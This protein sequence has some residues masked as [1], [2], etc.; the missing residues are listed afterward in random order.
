MAPKSISCQ[1][2]AN[3]EDNEPN[4]R[5]CENGHS[6]GHLDYESPMVR[7]SQNPS[8]SIP[9]KGQGKGV[10]ATPRTPGTDDPKCRRDVQQPTRQPLQQQSI[11]RYGHAAVY[12]EAQEAGALCGVHA[13]NCMLQRRAVDEHKM[14][15]IA[16]TL[17]QREYELLGDDARIRGDGNAGPDGNFTVQVLQEAMR[18]QTGGWSFTDTRNPTIRVRVRIKSHLEKGYFV[19]P[20]GHWYVLRRVTQGAAL[21]WYNLDS[22]SGEGPRRITDAEVLRIILDTETSGG[23]V[24]LAQTD[25]G[26]PPK[27]TMSSPMAAGVDAPAVTRAH[28]GRAPA[29]NGTTL[30]VA[31]DFSGMDMAGYMLR[32]AAVPF[33]H[34]FASDSS[35]AAREHL[36]RNHCVEAIYECVTQRPLGPYSGGRNGTADGEEIDLFIAGPPCQSWSLNRVGAKGEDD[37]RGRLFSESTTF[38]TEAKP[39]AF[40]LE[41]VCGLISR[42]GGRYLSRTLE[43]LR[44][45]GYR[46]RWARINPLELGLPQNRPRLY[47]W[48]VRADLSPEAPVVET[49]RKTGALTLS[50]ILGKG[51]PE[52]C[53]S[54]QNVEQLLPR[55]AAACVQQVAQR[56][57]TLRLQG[58]DWVIDEQVSR[59]R[60]ATRKATTHFPCLLS[61]RKKPPWIGSRIRRATLSEACRAQGLLPSMIHKDDWAQP[62]AFNQLLGNSMA[63]NA[64]SAVVIPLIRVIKPELEVVDPWE[65]G[66]IQYQLRQSATA[67]GDMDDSTVAAVSGKPAGTRTRQQCH[68]TAQGRGNPKAREP[69]HAQCR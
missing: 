56:H 50:D 5:H 65:T 20:G 67:E 33:R 22:L 24:H 38:I 30:K 18:C 36:R 29:L 69:D 27:D 58:A 10:G 35:P 53:A 12:W 23:T 3:C 66:S 40:V 11:R 13:V 44:T 63:A 61:S 7:N 19:N 51:T 43:I 25:D 48:G 55:A 6:E 49:T 41:N 9:H 15:S 57:D 59:A 1:R 60:H 47:I 4:S 62:T 34:L 14:R 37:P 31:T 2:E 8:H 21:V 68:G 32:Q 39:R 26:S 54:W 52:D 64:L 17:D 16:A 45:G 46:V 28:P 42:G